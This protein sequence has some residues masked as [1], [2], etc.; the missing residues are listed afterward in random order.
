MG[1]K[2][3]TPDLNPTKSGVLLYV[4]FDECHEKEKVG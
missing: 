2:E 3:L 1:Y 4:R